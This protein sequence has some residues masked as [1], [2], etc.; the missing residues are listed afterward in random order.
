L[1]G[2]AVKGRE[3]S[4]GKDEVIFREGDPSDAVYVVAKGAVELSKSGAGGQV[5]LARLGPLEMFG[6]TGIL[7]GSP[8]SATARTI[9][10]S[11]I[12]VIPKAEFTVWLQQEP[13]SAIRVVALLIERLR[14]AD[15]IIAGQRDDQS[16]GSAG[17]VLGAVRVWLRRRR[18]APSGAG[19]PQL[20]PFQ[21]GVATLNND[22]EGAWT[23]ALAGL[24]DGRAGI[25]ARSLS[26]SLQLD[27]AAD[28]AQVNAVTLKARQLIA[29]EEPLDLL[30]WGDVHAD[31]YSLH[32]TATVPGDEE[33]LGGFSPF[34]KLE[35]TGDQE[36]PAGDLFY[37]AVLAAIEPVNDNQRALQR[38]LLPVACQALPPLPSGLPA[39]WN[40]D[41]QRGA[42][43]CVGHA[44]AT[45]AV[46][47]GGN[48]WYDRAAEAYRTAL[49]RIPRGSHGIEEALLRKCLGIVLQASADRRHDADLLDKAV[50]E[51]RIAVECLV[52]GLYL[53]EWGAAQN[54]LGVAL[55][56]LDLVTGQ[57]ALL[58]EAMVA[59]QAAL[60][61]FPRNEVPQRWADVM[62]N[63]AQVL[64]V[65]GDQMKSPEVLERAIDAC[66][67]A[68]EYRVRSRTPLAWASSQN[69]LG[70]ALFLLDKHRQRNEHLDEAASAFTLALEVYRQMGAT[71][72]ATVAEK[73]LAHVERL[74]KSGGERKVVLPD[75]SDTAR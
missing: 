49:L 44:L 11:R 35:L 15:A 9:E 33:R 40:I 24:L 47:E 72:L 64:Q 19:D 18:S 14:A 51:F 6:E 37:S 41:Q 63:L 65:Y 46:F 43:A 42:L 12:K 23:R 58:K 21:V 73:N 61:A 71:R 45:V 28:Q 52:K 70:T 27:P 56:K 1:G 31:G 53:Q 69:T 16:D 36:P 20:Q 13:N 25:A 60:Q 3:R 55:Y 30:V 48:E 5:V 4:F 54:R 66:R 32:F 57:P 59:Y 50:H 74:K 68:L 39:A 29:R 62:N 22:I 17:G 10:K 2:K 8:R 67:S 38:Q 34:L 26:T 7:D 75:W